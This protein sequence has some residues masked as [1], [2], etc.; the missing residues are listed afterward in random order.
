M[1]LRFNFTAQEMIDQNRVTRRQ[2]DEFKVWLDT[3]DYP[4]LVEEQMVLFLLS[5]N[6]EMETTKATV[7]AHYECK[8]NRG[9]FFDDR[10]VDLV[11]LQQEL[12]AV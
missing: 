11:D 10:D 8:L 2:I 9:Q 1:A 6:C 5:C 7:K 12:K 4:D 3:Q